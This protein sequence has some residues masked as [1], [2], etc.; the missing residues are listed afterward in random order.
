M[1]TFKNLYYSALI[2]LTGSS[3]DKLGT[4]LAGVLYLYRYL[5]AAGS[6]SKPKF[7]FLFSQNLPLHHDTVYLI[8]ILYY[9]GYFFLYFFPIS[10]RRES[11]TT[12]IMVLNT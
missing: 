7:E 11:T 1:T 2:V 5:N 8:L 12:S 6:M 9:Y 4:D 10:A 3:F